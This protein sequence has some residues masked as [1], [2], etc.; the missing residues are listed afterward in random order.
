MK[1]RTGPFGAY[2]LVSLTLFGKP[3]EVEVLIESEE[4]PPEPNEHQIDAL[5]EFLSSWNAL[6]PDLER[7]LF[8]Y[9]REANTTIETIVEFAS[10]LTLTGLVVGY[11]D[12]EGWSDYLGLLFSCSWDPEHG[13]GVKIVQNKVFEIASQDIVI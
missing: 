7:K 8:D 6:V 12:G 2:A 4:E 10:H 13:V 11:H 5:L 3:A 9:Y 1:T